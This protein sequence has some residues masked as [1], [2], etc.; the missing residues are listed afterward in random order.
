MSDLPSSCYLH[1]FMK[2][3][4]FY[5]PE[6]VEIIKDHIY[7][8]A[9]LK[10]D[11]HIKKLKIFKDFP[12]T[13]I[14]KKIR[15]LENGNIF[16]P[17][18]YS[19]KSDLFMS[20]KIYNFNFFKLSKIDFKY[21]K[22]STLKNLIFTNTYIKEIIL[23]LNLKTIPFRCFANSKIEKV[24][25]NDKCECIETSAFENCINLKSI[26]IPEHIQQIKFKA[27]LKSGLITV[28]FEHKEKATITFYKESF[29]NDF[30]IKK[31]FKFKTSVNVNYKGSKS[32]CLNWK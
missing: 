1:L 10:R 26:I 22:N 5:I 23:P 14:C 21:L 19:F 16:Y 25:I 27:F 4:N 28:V 17:M 18:E 7:T 15:E 13:T 11:T 3:L 6:I 2:E 20:K 24:T 32:K 12:K 29:K 31:K 30:L 8:N 9:L